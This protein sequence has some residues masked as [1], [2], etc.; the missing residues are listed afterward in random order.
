[1]ETWPASFELPTTS[2]SGA[3]E[4][5]SIRTSM[6]SGAVRQRRR[7]TAER[8]V[9]SVKWQFSDLEMAVFTAFH[10]FRLNLGNDYFI[11]NLPVGGDV[12][13]HTVRFVDGKF[14]QAYA[15]VMHWDV[16]AQLEVLERYVIDEALMSVYLAVGFGESE[17][18]TLLA[19]FDGVHFAVHTTLHT[20]L[21]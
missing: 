9:L 8:L 1:M 21:N 13:P 3:Q 12:Q 7:F 4:A 19:A 6:D 5:N 14:A 10:K 17:I 20:N 18:S 15:D 16:T 2:F 11:M